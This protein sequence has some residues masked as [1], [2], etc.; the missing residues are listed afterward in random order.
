[1][2]Q[3][4]KDNSISYGCAIS[5]AS[6]AYRALKKGGNQKKEKKERENTMGE[7]FDTPK[8]PTKKRITVKPKTKQSKAELSARERLEYELKNLKTLKEKEDEKLDQSDFYKYQ[9][10]AWF[11]N[12]NDISRSNKYKEIQKR[13]KE[14]CNKLTY[15]KTNYG[16]E[17]IFIDVRDYFEKYLDYFTDIQKKLKRIKM[18]NNRIP[19]ETNK[20]KIKKNNE[21]FVKE[22]AENN[23][24]SNKQAI[25]QLKTIFSV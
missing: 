18:P 2:R 15:P 7:D 6:P 8:T 1:V 5:E 12:S 19:N 11:E 14:E 4:A 23:S 22:F 9:Y 21:D 13:I 3:Y 16:S 17:I 24:M 20:N 25:N 10:L